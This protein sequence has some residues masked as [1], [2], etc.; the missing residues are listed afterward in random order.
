MQN[1]NVE[2][3]EIGSLKEGVRKEGEMLWGRASKQFQ[4]CRIRRL[5]W[6]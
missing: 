6:R 4:I 1:S 2:R 5:H 3:K